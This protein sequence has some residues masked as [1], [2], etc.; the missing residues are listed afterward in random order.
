MALSCLLAVHG[1]KRMHTVAYPLL[2]V[3]LRLNTFCRKECLGREAYWLRAS[4]YLIST[5]E[6]SI[7]AYMTPGHSSLCEECG[8]FSWQGIWQGV[9]S[10]LSL[11]CVP[12]ESLGLN[13]L[14]LT[15][16]PGMVLPSNNVLKVI[17]P[18]PCL[19]RKSWNGVIHLSFQDLGRWRREHLWGLLGS[20][21]S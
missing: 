13:L 5:E 17:A 1:G 16:L 10:R 11:R 15:E 4:R 20:Q 2:R 9:G 19:K 6:N 12:T 14:Y 18:N 21:L 3:D 7:W 8:T